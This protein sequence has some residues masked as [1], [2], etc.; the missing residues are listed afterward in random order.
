MIAL[1]GWLLA[2]VLAVGLW[3]RN[4]DVRRWKYVAG[5]RATC[6]TLATKRAAWLERE[7]NRI[8]L[9]RMER[10]E[11]ER[12][13][14]MPAPSGCDRA[15]ARTEGEAAGPCPDAGTVERC[16][17]PGCPFDAVPGGL[18]QKCLDL[19]NSFDLPL[20]VPLRVL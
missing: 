1:I 10:L 16:A 18:C 7:L 6:W 12:L 5:Q 2:A 15:A 9:E 17:Q 8:N 11:T 3:F 4:D 19:A 13:G 14:A 20:R